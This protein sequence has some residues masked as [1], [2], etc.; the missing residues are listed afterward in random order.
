MSNPPAAV[1]AVV[2][3]RNRLSLLKATLARILTQRDAD[4]R[5]IVVDEA[6][7]DGTTDYLR[8]LSEC[9]ERVT[10][11]HHQRPHG[12]PAARNAGIA[13][14]QTEW[15]AFCDDDDL[16]APDKVSSQ[17]S[18]IAEVPGA[19]WSCTGSVFVRHDLTISGCQRAPRPGDISEEL[20][21]YNAVPGGGSS[22]LADTRLV[23]DLNGYDESLVSCEDW[24]LNTELAHASPIAPV[25]RPLVG[26]RVWAGT[27]STDVRRMRAGREQILDRW[28]DSRSPALRRQSKLMSDQYLGRLHIRNGAR[29]RGSAHYLRYAVS[30]RRPHLLQTALGM[31][32]APSVIAARHDLQDSRGVPDDWR[33]EGSAWLS[34]EPQ[35]FDC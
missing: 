25:D 12:L 34:E 31:L 30:S 19:R 10:V 20:L 32:L 11:I 24:A 23:L 14:V 16:W 9:D 7:S 21:I 35:G 28:A 26:Y 6:S 8:R 18:A 27:M 29:I 5:V 17:I 2:P 22:L 15:V 4:L 13:L 3:T 33:L 1:T